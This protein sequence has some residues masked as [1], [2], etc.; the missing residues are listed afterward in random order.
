ML[1]LEIIH[2]IRVEYLMNLIESD[3]IPNPNPNPGPSSKA[4]CLIV[5]FR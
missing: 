2:C 3:P 1:L 5:G 4:K